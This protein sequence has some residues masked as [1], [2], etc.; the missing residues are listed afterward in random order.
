MPDYGPLIHVYQT[1]RLK[2]R[3]LTG[4]ILA[5]IVFVFLPLV[6]GL[7]N[8]FTGYTQ[9]GPAAGMARGTP[10]LVFATLIGLVWL[11]LLIIRL[12]TP[13]FKILFYKNGLIFEGFPRATGVLG[14]EGWLGWESLSSIQVDTTRISPETDHLN[15]VKA[16][17]L[18]ANGKK[19]TLSENGNRP[20]GLIDLTELISRIKAALYQRLTPGM[21][22]AFAGGS[23]I[24]FGPLQI[25]KAG[26]TFSP[27]FAGGQT[28]TIPWDQV[29]H[30]TIQSGRLVIELSPAHSS[31]QIKRQFPVSKIPNLE[32]LLQIIKENVE[33]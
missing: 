25:S 23:R 27:S 30:L 8:Y 18:L 19:I 12:R 3:H 2:T 33:S 4:L 11:V 13:R 16:S 31:G 14:P 9:F 24:S 6:I 7:V 20:G 26:I 22:D 28:G 17:L 29:Q 1:R 21:K 5:G 32:L 15:N 10:W